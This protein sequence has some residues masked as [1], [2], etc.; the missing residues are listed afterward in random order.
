MFPE[1]VPRALRGLQK[2]GHV[3]WTW[4]RCGHQ[5]QRP[6]VRAGT[7]TPQP[8]LQPCPQTTSAEGHLP[9]LGL[10]I[11][12]KSIESA[13]CWGNFCQFGLNLE[14]FALCIKHT[15]HATLLEGEALADP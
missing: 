14:Q 1:C 9:P 13:E 2:A 8:C 10:G 3:Q 4:P 15:S 6:L 5:S 12:I 11:Q 7:A